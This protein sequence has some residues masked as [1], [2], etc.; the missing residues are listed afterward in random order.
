MV[1]KNRIVIFTKL[2]KYNLKKFVQILVHFLGHFSF[3]FLGIISRDGTFLIHIECSRWRTSF[4]V[5]YGDY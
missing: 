5:K 3:F 2:E 4:N 1:V